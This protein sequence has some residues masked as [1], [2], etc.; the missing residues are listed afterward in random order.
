MSSLFFLSWDLGAPL[1][2]LINSGF[3]IFW[4]QPLISKVSDI[5]LIII[6]TLEGLKDDQ[7]LPNWRLLILYCMKSIKIFIKHQMKLISD[8][9]SL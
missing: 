4:L 3:Q 9:A 7:F 1:G 2:F 5:V 8:V 6:C